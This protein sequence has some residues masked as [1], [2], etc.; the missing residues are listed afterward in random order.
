VNL[1]GGDR[2]VIPPAKVRDY[3]LSE[4][5]P[6]G[7]FKARVFRSKGFSASSPEILA[8]ELGRVAAEGDVESTEDNPYGRKYRVPG[9]LVGP[10]GSIEVLTVWLIATG[11]DVP[12]LVTAQ[13]R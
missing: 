2:A 5:H 6:V 13:P 4:T 11:T 3:L 1:P 8:A 9:I 10:A 12:V 7:R